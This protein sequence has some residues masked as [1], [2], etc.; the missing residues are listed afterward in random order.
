MVARPLELW[1]LGLTPLDAT[2]LSLR[3]TI[4]D[5]AKAEAAWPTKGWLI[6]KRFFF[7]TY[8]IILKIIP[9]VFLRY[10]NINE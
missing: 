1:P 2:A 6:K 5:R 8:M 7:V 3:A 10:S 4:S 9:C